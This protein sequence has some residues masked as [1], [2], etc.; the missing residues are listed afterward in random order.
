[1][2][3]PEEFNRAD[4]IIDGPQRVYFLGM[5]ELIKIG[6]SASLKKRINQLAD[7]IPY[8]ISLLHDIPGDQELEAYYHYRFRA[9]RFRGEWFHRHDDILKHIEELKERSVTHGIGFGL[10]RQFSKFVT[11]WKHSNARY[12]ATSGNSE[13]LR[14]KYVHKSLKTPL[15]RR[16]AALLRRE[17]RAAERRKAARTHFWEYC[18]RAAAAAAT[19]A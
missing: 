2:T 16:E 8:E 18:R 5:N 12:S 19:S 7:A 11:P 13:V 17:L 3:H 14:P 1:M 15:N 4:Q 9:Q 6:Y 10:K